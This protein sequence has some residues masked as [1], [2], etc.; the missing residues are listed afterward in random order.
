MPQRGDTVPSLTF[1]RPQQS[2]YSFLTQALPDC[3]VTP[4]KA[5]DLGFL[6]RLYRALRDEELACTGW[7]DAAKREFCDSQFDL[8]HKDW[9]G[10]FARAWFLIVMR[11]KLPIGRL[12]LDS[13]GESFHVI[14]IGLLPGCRGNGLGTALLTAIQHQATSECRAVTLSV[15]HGN[16]RAKDLYLRLGFQAE[17]SHPAYLSLRW[18]P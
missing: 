16:Q 14:D 17:A 8:Q 12:Y 1:P 3:R 6:R 4:A 15:A 13:L 7:P 2:G 11:R 5:A 9:T 18:T 10:R